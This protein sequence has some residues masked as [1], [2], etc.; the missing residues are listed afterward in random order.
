MSVL[1]RKKKGAWWVFITY[2]GQ[3][4]AKKVGTREAAERV[5]REIEA[6]LALG[7]I[8]IFHQ[9]KNT[10]SFSEYGRQWLEVHARAHCKTSTYRSYEQTFRSHLEPRFG[11]L[12]L[13]R[14]ARNELKHFMSG[15]VASKQYGLGTLR[16]ILATAR[17]I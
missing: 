6:R 5:K 15:L 10:V 14:I 12:P 16:K 3:R 13:E 8:G 1:V 2:H 17:A 4:K 9:K 11:S 7:D